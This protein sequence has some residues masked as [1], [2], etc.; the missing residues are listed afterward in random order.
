VGLCFY[1]GVYNEVVVNLQ[2]LA[3]I[4]GLPVVA[5]GGVQPHLPVVCSTPVSSSIHQYIVNQAI[6]ILFIE[7]SGNISV[8]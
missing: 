3:G 6:I 7:I 5:A 4:E 8:Q 2:E 1:L